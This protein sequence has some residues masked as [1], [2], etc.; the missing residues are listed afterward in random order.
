MPDSPNRKRHS[1]GVPGLNQGAMWSLTLITAV[2]LL[3]V[4]MVMF[5]TGGGP[6]Y[7]PTT[8]AVLSL[9]TG[10][11]AGYCFRQRVINSG[12]LARLGVFQ[13]R[14]DFEAQGEAEPPSG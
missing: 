2:V 11:L 8:M 10:F 13:L 7:V 5:W 3:G 6:L 14:E 12:R 4:S 1:T 9:P